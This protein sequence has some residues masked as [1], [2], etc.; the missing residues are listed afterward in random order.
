[1]S[2]RRFKGAHGGLLDEKP[3]ALEDFAP[4]D[5]GLDIGQERDPERPEKPAR[6]AVHNWV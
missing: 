5:G 2:R 1:V 4:Q 6:A 3:W